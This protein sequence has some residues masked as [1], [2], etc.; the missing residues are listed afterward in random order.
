[1]TD[2]GE[3][4]STLILKLVGAQVGGEEGEGKS[5]K[6]RLKAVAVGI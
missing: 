2:L 1:M 5:A 6:D 3:R 4:R